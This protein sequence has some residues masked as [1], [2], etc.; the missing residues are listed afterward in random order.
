MKIMTLMITW[1]VFQTATA[2]AAG[3]YVGDVVNISMRTAPGF[4]QDVIQMIT[5]GQ[6]IEV[7]EKTKE[8]YLIRLPDGKEGWVLGRY[9]TTEKPNVL[10]LKKLEEEHQKILAKENLLQQQIDKLKSENSQLL[11]ERENF[12]KQSIEMKKAYDALKEDSAAFL[13]LQS[14]YESSVAEINE[15]IQKNN[16][17]GEQLAQRNILFFV[18]GAGVLLFGF[19]IGFSTNK[20]RRRSSLLS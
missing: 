10:I 15:Q 12:K 2:A 17:L 11:V 5:S 14:K 16:S 6:E 7:I 4:N 9:I 18:I 1:L 19:F 8:W 3:M 13:E 20:N